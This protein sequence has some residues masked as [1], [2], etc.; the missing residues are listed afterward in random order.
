MLKILLLIGFLV[1]QGRGTSQ[2]C[3]KEKF[4]Q[5]SFVCVCNATYCDS[6]DAT[7]SLIDQNSALVVTSDKESK[8]LEVKYVDFG[9]NEDSSRIQFSLD[10]NIRYQE[11]LGFGGAF[12]DS[13][14]VNIFDFDNEDT[15][16][17]LMASY[18]DPTGLDY[19]TGRVNMGG[20]DF[21]TRPYTHV[22]T[23]GDVDLDTFELQ[24]EDYMKVS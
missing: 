19:S 10:E 16:N 12:T 8:R 24:E 11:M 7:E 23:P 4:G 13:A 14:A 3:A 22:D 5:D 17:N 20:C 6:L 1:C 2:P 18:F 21:S 15:I 9:T